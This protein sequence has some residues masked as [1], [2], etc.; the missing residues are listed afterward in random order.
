MTQKS[1]TL[2]RIYCT[3]GEGRMRKLL[4]LLHDVEKV[5]GVTVFRGVAGFGASGRIHTAGLVDLALEL[6][7]VLEFFDERDKVERIIAD[8]S[9]SVKPGH[10]V[11]W[12]I[13][14]HG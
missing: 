2:V 5:R 3:E 12:P 9:A 6:P 1:M 7:L 10:I 8:L 4:K 14:V 11:S 13:T